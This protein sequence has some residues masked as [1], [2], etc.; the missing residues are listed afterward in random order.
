MTPGDRVSLV[1]LL[2]LGLLVLVVDVCE[3]QLRDLL[4]RRRRGIAPPARLPRWD[5]EAERR[6]AEIESARADLLLPFG[7]G[8]CGQD[9]PDGDPWCLACRAHVGITGPLA[10]RTY[11]SLHGVDCPHARP[12]IEETRLMPG[13]EQRDY[14]DEDQ[15]AEGLGVLRRRPRP[16]RSQIISWWD[17][18]TSARLA[19]DEARRALE[20]HS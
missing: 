10:A 19:V 3:P 14:G 17:L 16:A 2:A 13:V 6:R 5:P 1:L 18:D 9:C 7:C 8:C 12:P 15:V 11:F 20:A 4:Q